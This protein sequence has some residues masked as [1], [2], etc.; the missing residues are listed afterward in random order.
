MSNRQTAPAFLLVAAGASR[1]ADPA[2]RDALV[3]A[4]TAAASSDRGMAVMLMNALRH[5]IR[6]SASTTMTSAVIVDST[7]RSFSTAFSSAW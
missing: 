7:A 6:K 2:R 3:A 4:A 1:L 5:S